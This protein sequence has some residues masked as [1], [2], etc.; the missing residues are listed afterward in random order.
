MKRILCLALACLL[1]GAVST[2]AMAAG[3]SEE[4][5]VVVE[6]ITTFQGEYRAEVADGEASAGDITVTDIP[7][8][9]MTLV[10]VPME[11]A[12]LSWIGDCLRDT[13]LRC[14]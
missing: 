12:A 11:G 6:H 3:A 8:G 14:L 7:D 1:L 10:V 5:D 2:A 13:P 9:T 4:K